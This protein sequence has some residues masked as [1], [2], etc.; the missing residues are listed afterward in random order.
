MD[1][2]HFKY[3]EKRKSTEYISIIILL[4][5]CLPCLST[6]ICTFN[7]EITE[8]IIEN[9]KNQEGIN[10]SSDNFQS[11]SID[12]SQEDTR[13]TETIYQQKWS[14]LGI[15][16]LPHWLTEI[17]DDHIDTLLANDFTE[18]RIELPDWDNKDD[19]YK[20]RIMI[21]RAVSKGAK[22]VWG[23]TNFGGDDLTSTTWAN[24]RA[25]VLTQA[26]WAE[27]NGVFEFQIGNEIENHIDGTTLTVAQLINNL[28][29]LA[30]EVQAIFTSGNISYTCESNNISDWVTAGKGDI[31]IIASNV[32]MEDD[33]GNPEPW[34][35]K[36]SSLV[37]GFGVNGTYLSE[38]GLSWSGVDVYS[39]DEAIQA[40]AVTEMIDYIKASGMTRAFYF[41]YA[42]MSWV[43]GYG[44]LKEDG[45]Y[46]LLWSQALLST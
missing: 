12:L 2:K 33:L 22:I 8:I 17:F 28:K 11:L 40:A 16:L 38:F 13:L 44:A 20:C 6:I 26:A 46:R 37:S 25:E 31:D 36:I 30:T 21:P 10:Q 4:L 32:Y 41:F 15:N 35:D 42:D 34:Q 9:I 27:A 43:S 14:G 19:I 29:S 24:F 23:I 7:T 5:L 1:I 3:I 45:T 39:E 18:I